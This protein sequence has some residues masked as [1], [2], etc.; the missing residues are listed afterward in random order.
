MNTADLALA[1]RRANRRDWKVV[2]TTSGADRAEP[3]V[4]P[5]QALEMM[6]Q[7]AL[8]AWAMTGQPVPDYPRGQAPVRRVTLA[9]DH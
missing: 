8:D 7:L 5:E 1:L 3:L 2:R 4:P 9:I 6:W